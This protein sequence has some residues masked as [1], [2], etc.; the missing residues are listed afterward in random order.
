MQLIEKIFEPRRLFLVW[1]KLEMIRDQQRPAGDRFKIAE[2]TKLGVENYQFRY[3]HGTEKFDEAKNNGFEG[4]PGFRLDS[5]D[6]VG[7]NVL[8]TFNNRIFNQKRQDFKDFLRYYGLSPDVVISD[9]A[10]LGYTGGELPSDNFS[11]VVDFEDAEFPLDIP[12]QIVGTRHYV[13]DNTGFMKG[14]FSD[15]ETIS[16]H[17]LDAMVVK[18]RPEPENPKDRHAIAVI[19]EKPWPGK[20]GYINRILAEQVTPW[21]EFNTV[22]PSVIRVN[23]TPDLPNIL[24]KLT[25]K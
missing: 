6:T 5:V 1:Q 16:E 20:I 10:L 9:F 7:Q 18:L 25:V 2:L 13:K 8:W 19:M 12:T 14:V 24:L 11:F 22:R 17:V 23:G 3:L 15:N 21:L 4:F